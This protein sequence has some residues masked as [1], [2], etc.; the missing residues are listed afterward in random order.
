MTSGRVPRDLA[1]NRLTRLLETKRAGAAFLDL[2]I[3]D[4]GRAGLAPPEAAAILSALADPRALGHAPG[5]RGDRAAREAAAAY[6]GGRAGHILDPDRVFFTSSTSEAYAHL[7]RLLCDPGDEVLVPRPS[8]PLIEPIARVEDVGVHAYRLVY[9]GSWR[10]DADSL[11]ASLTDRTRAVVLVEPN[12]PT[13]S[14]LAPE[15]FAL[16]EE[17]CRERGL[18]LIVDEVFGDL[19]WPPREGPLPSRLG[20]RTAPTFVLG[21]I[22]KPCG[23]PQLKLGWIAACGPEP[24]LAELLPGLD[25]VLD[26]FL[27]VGAPVQAALPALLE[28][29]H[30]YQAALRAR[31]RES[32]AAIEEAAQRRPGML[33]ALGGGAGLSAVLRVRHERGGPRAGEDLA[34]WA[35]AERDV[36]LHPAHFYDLSRDDLV[37]AS[38]L[39]PGAW[40]REALERI[41]EG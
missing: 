17:R 15:E 33:Q 27:S 16:V 13:G 34:E 5:P 1:P 7:F 30:A 39:T 9:D 28:T 2:T 19:V 8:Y 29:R 6:L 11:D 12:N 20:E 14:C 18:A 32:L 10:L 25:W 41:L 40:M 26:L 22:S 31:L 21:G 23:L 4:P 35:L 37:V 24:R 38:L 3:T 36:Y